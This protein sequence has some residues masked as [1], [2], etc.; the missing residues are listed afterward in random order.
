[1]I[2]QQTNSNPYRQQMLEK[3]YSIG[4][5]YYPSRQ[6]RTFPLTIAGFT[7]ETEKEYNDAIADFLNG[8]W[9]WTH[10]LWQIMSWNVSGISFSQLVIVVIRVATNLTTLR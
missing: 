6:K 2:N 8:N 9:T 3:S 1:M 4:E 7:F 5:T 10:F